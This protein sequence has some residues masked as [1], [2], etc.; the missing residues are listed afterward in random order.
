VAI[1]KLQLCRAHGGGA[2]PKNSSSGGSLGDSSQ[3]QLDF[4]SFESSGVDVFGQ[5]HHEDDSETMANI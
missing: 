1:G 4:Q 5:M 2:R 3:E